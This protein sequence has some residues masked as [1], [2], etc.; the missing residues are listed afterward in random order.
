MV[1]G[2]V[3]LTVTWNCR[4]VWLPAASV[5][6]AV[7]VVVPFGK[8]VPDGMSVVTLAVPQLSVAL[9]AKLTTAEQEPA[10]LPT[11]MSA[12]TLSVGG[13]LSMTVMVCVALAWLPPVSVA[14][15]VR[16]MTSGLLAEPAPLRV[17]ETVTVGAMPQLS[18][19]VA[20]DGLAA[21]TSL[22]HVEPASG[23]ALMTG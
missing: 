2:C 10:S 13:V 14:V 9:T 4:V 17:S 3:S 20:C 12:G 21:G 8:V 1:G 5:A 11:V 7:T 22:G 16:L 18:V 19:A 6:V 23:G 15:K